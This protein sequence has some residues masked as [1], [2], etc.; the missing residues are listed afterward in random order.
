MQMMVV[1]NK[2]CLSAIL[3]CNTL[4]SAYVPLSPQFLGNGGTRG[5]WAG[6]GLRSSSISPSGW[7]LGRQVAVASATGLVRRDVNAK[8]RADSRASG[9]GAV[10]VSLGGSE[11]GIK[12]LIISGPSGVGKVKPCQMSCRENMLLSSGSLLLL[13]CLTVVVW[14]VAVVV[15]ACAKKFISLADLD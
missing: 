2:Y 14:L 15:L 13:Q 1:W 5:S 11:A 4:A 10:A 6:L 8:G 7:S 3:A 12:P 9:V